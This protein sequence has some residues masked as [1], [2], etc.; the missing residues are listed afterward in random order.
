MTPLSRRRALAALA[1][2]ATGGVAGCASGESVTTADDGGSTPTDAEPTLLDRY[3]LAADHGGDGGSAWTA[4]ET[5]PAVDS[6]GTELLVENLEIPWDISV[7]GDGTLFVTERVGRLRS[8][9]GD[10]VSTVARPSDAIDA[11]SLDPGADVDPFENWFLEGGEGGML[12]VAA[13]PSYPDPPVVYV[14]YTATTDDGKRNRV[15]AI[16]TDADDPTETVTPVV[17]GIPAGGVHNGGRITF[18]PENYLWVCCGDAGEADRAQDPA[19][20]HGTVLRVT[21]TGD[22]APDNPGLADP[23]IY[24]Y[25]HR[26]PQGLV[27]T[28]DGEPLAS[29]HGPN[30]RDEINHL[31]AG[32]NSGWPAV[33]NREAYPAEGV[34]SPLANSGEQSWAPTGSVF[35]TGEDVPT[36]SNRLLVGGLF[37][38]QLLVATVTPDGDPLPPADG[39]T[40]YDHAWTDDTYTVTTHAAFENE[41]GRIRHVEQGPGGEVYVVTSNRDGRAKEGFPREVDDVLVRVTQS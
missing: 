29:E 15:A 8:V 40:R 14:Y 26:N 28:P 38:Q 32:H 6:L 10:A 20:L 33:R 36:L 39:G 37:S 7:A 34:H 21:P 25:G 1:A 18:G 11:E 30:G 41:L 22:P 3:D 12:G 2:G 13:H 23:R 5:A 24:T 16:D 27:F 4:P 19:T 17:E 9:D 35:Y 31:V